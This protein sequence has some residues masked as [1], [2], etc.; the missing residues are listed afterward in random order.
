MS[1]LM[2]APRECASWFW[3]LDEY[4]PP[5]LQ[6]ALKAA[7]H[8]VTVL[9]KYDLLEPQ[10]LQWPWFIPGTGGAPAGTRLQL[11]TPIDDDQVLKR[12]QEMRPVSFPD[13]V[14]GDVLVAGTGIWLDEDGTRRRE[15]RLVELTVSPEPFGLSAEIALHHDIWGPY[16]FRGNPHPGVQR[17]NAPR[18]AAALKELDDMLGV[19]AEPGEATYFGRAEGY[20]VADP[21]VTDGRGPD[22]TSQL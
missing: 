1:M 8:M 14:A 22:L 4:A 17:R 9:R 21:E 12:I 16:D 13:A 10:N 18:L 7:A 15:Y 20:G 5:G 3:D 19:A 11:L 2:R 6:S